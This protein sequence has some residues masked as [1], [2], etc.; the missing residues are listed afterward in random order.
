MNRWAMC[1]VRGPSSST[2]SI[3]REGIDRQPEPEHLYGA[4]QPG[5]QFVQ[6]HVWE[7]EVRDA[8]TC[9]RSERASPR[10]R[11]RLVMVACRGPCDPWSFRRIQPTSQGRQHHGDPA[12]EGV[13]K[14][15]RGVWR[16]AVKV[17]RQAGPR[18][19]ADPLG[20]AMLAIPKKPRG[21]DPR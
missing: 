18:K 7:L 2:G 11:E 21:S 1:C 9:A 10:A 8:S 20:L 19:V 17:V 15:E 16:R 6:L 13:F 12:R 14:R 3:A 5:A 4:A